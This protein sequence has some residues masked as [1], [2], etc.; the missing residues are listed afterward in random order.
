VAEIHA[1]GRCLCAVVAS[2]RHGVRFGENSHDMQA[3]RRGTV[4]DRWDVSGMWP[5]RQWC[6]EGAPLASRIELDDSGSG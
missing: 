5:T 6:G 1:G 4:A 2:S 3:L